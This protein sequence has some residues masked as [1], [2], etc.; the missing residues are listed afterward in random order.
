MWRT[1]F[2]Y[3]LFS[4]QP[5]GAI[6]PRFAHFVWESRLARPRTTHRVPR[7]ALVRRGRVGRARAVSRARSE[8]DDEEDLE[9]R[10]EPDKPSSLRSR[11]TGYRN[12]TR[13][14]AP[15]TTEQER[16]NLFSKKREC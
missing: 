13:R 15:G 2:C 8:E 1:I 16:R 7:H 3:F 14:E 9:D 6:L 11:L 5:P 12:G 4:N 10:E